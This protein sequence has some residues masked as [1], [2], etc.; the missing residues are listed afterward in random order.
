MLVVKALVIKEGSGTKAQ[1]S[2]GMAEDEEDD[3]TLSVWKTSKAEEEKDTVKHAHHQN[4]H[5]DWGRQVVAR[6]LLPSYTERRVACAT[7]AIYT[8]VAGHA[9]HAAGGKPMGPTLRPPSHSPL[10]Y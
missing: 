8:G 9:Q 6:V 10:R 2:I 7:T 4:R 1:H 3:G 5:W